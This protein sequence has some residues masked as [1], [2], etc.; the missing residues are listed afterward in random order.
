M[1]PLG[2][3]VTESFGRVAR[4]VCLASAATMLAFG[5]AASSTITSQLIVR[6]APGTITGEVSSEDLPVTALTADSSLT[7]ALQSLGVVSGRRVFPGYTLADSTRQLDSGE[8]VQMPDLTQVML[9]TLQTPSEATAA[10]QSLSENAKVLHSEP[11][12]LLDADL[13]PYDPAFAN[14]QRYAWDDNYGVNT[15]ATIAWGITTGSSSVRI[16]IIDN[17]VNH[18]HD[19]LGG[20]FGIKVIDGYN[21]RDNSAAPSHLLDYMGHGSLIAGIIGALTSN[22]KAGSYVGMAGLVGGWGYNADTGTGSTGGSL[23]SFVIGESPTSVYEDLASGVRAIVEASDPARYHCSIVNCSWGQVSYS[24]ALDLAVSIAARMNCVVVASKN[25]HQSPATNDLYY[26]VDEPDNWLLSVGTCNLD[27]TRRNYSG[28]GNG[29]DL[30]T[31]GTDIAGLSNAS[32]S[33]ISV[34]SGTS[35]SAPQV[36]GAA[37]LIL[38]QVP[39][40]HRDDV[41]GILTSAANDIPP[42]G[43]DEDTGAGALNIGRALLLT[44]P[45]NGLLHRSDFGRTSTASVS[46]A[47]NQ[48]FNDIGVQFVRRYDIRKVVALPTGF[49]ATP[50]V[51]G[52]GVNATVGWRRT[53]GNETNFQTGFCDVTSIS[54]TTAELRTYVYNRINLNTG[55]STGD[56]YPVA[57]DNVHWEYTVLGEYPQVTAVASG[58]TSL[59]FQAVGTWI[60]TGGGGDG[61]FTYEWR[62]R[63]TSNDPWSAVQG[64]AISYTRTMSNSSFQVQ[65]RVSSAG[66]YAYS[67]VDVAYTGDSVAPGQV[68]NLYATNIGETS[69][70][71][72]WTSPGDDGGSGTATAYDLRYST[73]TITAGNFASATPVSPQ[74]TPGSGGSAAQYTFTG[75][76]P[77]LM[78]NFALRARDEVSNWSAMSNVTVAGVSATTS[79]GGGGDEDPPIVHGA[80]RDG[81]TRTAFRATDGAVRL[82]VLLGPGQSPIQLRIYNVLGKLV[83][84]V[85]SGE[86]S[87][88]WH[89]FEWRLEDN[90]GGRISPGVYFASLDVSGMRRVSRLVLLP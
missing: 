47:Y 20:G 78:Y 74:P 49:T 32:A 43:E 46:D 38:S 33:L 89:D 53:A 24:Y 31:P 63:A 56:W 34:G 9:L 30:V 4:L 72:N 21:Y 13:I 73:A 66:M 37:A 45:P 85:E 48:L 29:I 22:T 17:G 23:L 11:N 1:R 59:G 14:L 60:A 77:C 71:L 3:A 58:P 35:F 76:D 62:Y 10:N 18:L 6:F 7:A 19:D 69:I 26:P 68:G 81:R 87:P 57:P 61:A 15:N 16:G 64:T 54:N 51:W 52:R 82:R 5:S 41:E 39:G 12:M 83:R 28:F 55:A 70:R 27:G 40:M 88:G 2:S 36:A 84:T 65:L 90:G 67:V 75:R 50:Y 80:G 25:D 86:V 8:I 44:V 79:C 42:T